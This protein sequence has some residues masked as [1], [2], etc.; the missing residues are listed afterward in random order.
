MKSKLKEESVCPNQNLCLIL[1]AFA[2]KKLGYMATAVIS[3]DGDIVALRYTFL[4][5]LPLVDSGFESFRV[6]K[7]SFIF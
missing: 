6:F 2:R 7:T 1:L 3:T 4:I 5:N